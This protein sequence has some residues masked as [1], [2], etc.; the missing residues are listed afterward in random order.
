MKIID[1]FIF[2]N[3]LDLLFYRLSILNEYVDYFILVESTHTFAGKEKPLFYYENKKLFELFNDKIIHIIID[4]FPYK[5]PNINYEHNHQWENEYYQRN[6]IKKGIDKILNELD[7]NDIILTS[8]IDEIPN[9][10]ILMKAKNNSLL[11][12]HDKLNRLALDMYCYNLYYRV[13]EGSNWHGI[14]LMSVNAYKLINLSFQ[15]MRTFEWKNHVFIIENGGWHLSYFGDVDFVINKISNFSHQEYNNQKYIE[16]YKLEE[17]IKNGINLL[18]DTNLVYIP[19]N[20]NKNLPYKYDTFLRKYY[21][22]S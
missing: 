16:K 3:E 13:G 22:S 1:S 7:E 9:P 6:Y 15:Q 4:D 12:D 20:E 19:I 10:K 11:F 5:F 14:K 8:D 2:Y 17:K 21:L 18:N